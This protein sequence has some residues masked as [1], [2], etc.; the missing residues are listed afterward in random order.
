MLRGWITLW[1]RLTKLCTL[2]QSLSEEEEEEEEEEE[3][4]EGHGKEV[5]GDGC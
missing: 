1:E 3:G 5:R 2:E 4:W